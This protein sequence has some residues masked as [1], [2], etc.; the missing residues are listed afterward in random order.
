MDRKNTKFLSEN[1]LVESTFYDKIL[2][3]NVTKRKN[4]ISV[5]TF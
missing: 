1:V 2:E 5:K 4:Y 3:T